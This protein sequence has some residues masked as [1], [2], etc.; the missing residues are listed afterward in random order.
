MQQGP[1]S[2][3][4]VGGNLTFMAWEFVVYFALTVLTEYSLTFPSLVA[5]LYSA[6]LDDAGVGSLEDEDE[7]VMAERSRVLQGGADTDIVKLSELRKVYAASGDRLTGSLYRA[8]T[9]AAAPPP[10]QAKVKVA[11]Q[12]LCFGIPKG[13]CFGF[14]GELYF[15]FHFTAA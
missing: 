8:V 11:V 2:W 15:I 14:L 7:D 1:F 9:C 12:S 10:G 6:G 13:E 3:D 5:W 4:I